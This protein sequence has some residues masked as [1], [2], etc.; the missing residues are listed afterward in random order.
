MA[1]HH[2]GKRFDFHIL[3]RGPLHQGEIANLRLRELDVVDHLLRQG[4]HAIVNFA[5]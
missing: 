5:F 2:A 3:K 4:A 1:Q